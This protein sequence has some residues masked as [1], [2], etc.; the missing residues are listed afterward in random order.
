MISTL[1]TQM[2]RCL[3]LYGTSLDAHSAKK[4]SSVQSRSRAVQERMAAAS[5]QTRDHWDN[6]ADRMPQGKEVIFSIVI[7]HVPSRAVFQ[8]ATKS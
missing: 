4:I 1:R 3:L 2:K 7:S 8:V 5:I 6:S